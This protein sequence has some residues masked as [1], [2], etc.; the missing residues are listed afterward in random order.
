MS[1]VRP[2]LLPPR[3]LRMRIIENAPS[4]PCTQ[5]S[6][7]VNQIHP[8]HTPLG[9]FTA[10]SRK[11]T[12]GREAGQGERSENWGGRGGAVAS[13]DLASGEKRTKRHVQQLATHCQ[14]TAV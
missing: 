2:S 5:P 3:S 11:T 14:L 10:K 12:Q 4:E 13:E 6:R 8:P 1:P 9:D 7:S